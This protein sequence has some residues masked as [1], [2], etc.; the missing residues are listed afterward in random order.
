MILADILNPHFFEEIPSFC[1]IPF[2]LLHL[3]DPDAEGKPCV[4]NPLHIPCCAFK[5]TLMRCNCIMR[6][7]VVRIERCR[8]RNTESTKNT[9]KFIRK[10]CE[11]CEY[12][13]ELKLFQKC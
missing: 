6:F 5:A 8:N 10:S 2:V 4:Q 9:Q 1:Q 11:V 7:G 3:N 12:L 13:N